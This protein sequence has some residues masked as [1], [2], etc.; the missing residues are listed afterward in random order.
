MTI[1]VF[2]DGIMAADSGVF[3]GDRW[4]GAAT[5]I[6][7]GRD[8]G[9][10]GAAGTRAGCHLFLKWFEQGSA[11]QFVPPQDDGHGFG[12]LMVDPSGNVTRMDKHG[13]IYPS[14]NVAYHIEGCAEDIAAGALEAGATAEEA[15]EIVCRLH[16]YCRLPVD[17][18]KL[19]TEE[20]A[21]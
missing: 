12:A 4:S 20:D 9:L 15:V 8:G 21:R 19:W 16:P 1:I 7:R 13:T 18:L 5:K 3:A 11:G 10:A 2:T 17:S 6:V 14:P